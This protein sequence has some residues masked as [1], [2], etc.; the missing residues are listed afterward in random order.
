MQLHSVKLFGTYKALKGTADHP[1]EI[2]F[3]QTRENFSPI[4]LVGLNGS[5][6]S[7]FIE[8]IADIFCYADRHLNRQF[9][10]RSDLPYDFEIEY[11]ILR[12]DKLTNVKLCGAAGKLKMI[13]GKSQKVQSDVM[14]EYLPD[15]V[16]AYSSGHN[17]GLSTVFSKN[18]YA[19]FDAIRKQGKFHKNYQLQYSK[20]RG[21]GS[22]EDDLILRRLKEYQATSYKRNPKLF[23]TP[24]QETPEFDPHTVLQTIPP[25]PPT[26][27][28]SDHDA[29]QLIFIAACL[30]RKEAFNQLTR[31]EI[32]VSGLTSFELDLQLTSYKEIEF[33]EEA[34]KRLISVASDSSNFD[35][36][37][38]KGRLHFKNDSDFTRKLE[39]VFVEGSEG[40]F[41]LLHFL[42]LLSAKKW[43]RDETVALKTANYLNNVP[44]PAGGLA[45]VRVINCRVRLTN[46]DVETLYDRL[47]DGEHQFAQILGALCLFGDRN[48]LFILDEPE[49]HFNPHWRA[50]FV[51]ITQ[52]AIRSVNRNSGWPGIVIS[53]HSPFVVSGCKKENVFKFARVADDVSVSHPADETYGA[54]FDYLLSSLFDMDVLMATQARD[55]LRNVLRDG[56]VNQL[57]AAKSFFGNSIEKAAIFVRLAELEKS[58]DQK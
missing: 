24:G 9:G 2:T 12:D 33:V 51:E 48:T 45:P 15:K 26:V 55:E 16:V 19:F 3:H 54:S 29:N 32:G 11:G 1:I 35:A 25:N 23:E 28:F 22:R 5:G 10:A 21:D 47:S 43:G 44:I 39:E 4:C 53:T 14:R 17:Q 34:V 8:L 20:F 52:R 49:S 18:Q 38:L 42:W 57:K 37:R 40:I 58:R 36:D 41:N 6:K 27:I 31:D 7:S 56:N 46:P 50:E 13:L 30:A